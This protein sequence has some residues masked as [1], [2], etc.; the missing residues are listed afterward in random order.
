MNV[1]DFDF[2]TQNFLKEYFTYYFTHYIDYG[3]NTIIFMKKGNFYEIYGLFN[4]EDDNEN[5]IILLSK[6]LDLKIMNDSFQ[7][8]NVT[9]KKMYK[10]I[11][12]GIPEVKLEKYLIKIKDMNFTIVIVD[13]INNNNIITRYVKSII[14][15]GTYISED[16]DINKLTNNTMCLWIEK[17]STKIYFGLSSIDIYTGSSYIYEYNSD[18]AIGEM[19]YTEIERNISQ[20]QPTEFIIISNYTEKEVDIVLE[21]LKLKNTVIHKINIL[22]NK[23]T[24]NCEKQTYQEEILK[25]YYTFNDFS[26]F[27]KNFDTKI[28]A[29]QSYCYL[30]DFINSH[31]NYLLKNLNLPIFE[32]YGTRVYLSNYAYNQLNFIETEYSGKSKYSSIQ[33]MLNNCITPIGKRYFDYKIFN[34]TTDIIYLNKEYNIIEYIISLTIQHKNKIEKL[35]TNICDFEKILRKIFTDK[36]NYK[37][38]YNIYV[39]LITTCSIIDEIN[40]IDNNNIINK[41]LE[42]TINKDKINEIILFIHSN[43]NIENCKMFSKIDDNQYIIPKKDSELYLIYKKN[44]DSTVILE[45]I[46]NYF[47]N[48]INISNKSKIFIDYVKI[49]EDFNFE[50]TIERSKLFTKILDSIIQ[51]II[52]IN[53]TSPIDNQD[54]IYT[55]D[56][57]DITFSKHLKTKYILTCNNIIILQDDI[58]QSKILLNKLNNNQYYT[59]I[60]ELETNYKFFHTLN[61]F[62]SIIDFIYCKASIA[63]KFNYCKPNIELANNS[64]IN[65]IELRH[66]IIE[67]INENEFYTGN[68]LILGEYGIILYGHNYGGK[69]SL[70][71][72][73]GINILLAQSG[74]YVAASKFKYFPYSNIFVLINKNDNM[75][76]NLSLFQ[77][78]MVNINNLLRMANNNSLILMDELVSSTEIVSTEV[79]TMS[80]IET[81]I[82]YKSSFILSSHI[83]TLLK[84]EHIINSINNNLLKI[85]HIEMEFD[86]YFN[87]IIYNRKIKEGSG[88]KIYGVMC[89]KTLNLP[90]DFMNLM[91]SIMNKYFREEKS[92]L[93]LKTSK[94]NSKKLTGIICENCNLEISKDVHH[95]YHQ[96]DADK[97]GFI[98]LESGQI[99]HKNHRLNLRS[100]CK[101]CHILIHSK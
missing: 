95:V 34:P 87:K 100:I 43:F 31:N 82:S 83:H 99:I 51:K 6:T 96:A 85:Y 50:I 97:N 89:T 61:S 32:C 37:Y 84:Y 68:D 7:I 3:I 8:E 62:I 26:V 27:I 73:I 21:Y 23:K 72:S 98:K 55:L 45:N 17:T 4:I 88:S 63:I 22:N 67:I 86:S 74:F 25:K 78:E 79:I 19:M 56:I 69:S 65:T 59:T 2:K 39:V 35:L 49:D 30:L 60:Q 81:L 70:I 12:I 24:E 54:Y 58:I 11:G 16:E 53:Y 29:T 20:K 33:K 64:F 38:I 76:E 10:I 1:C 48:T 44:I 41:Y 36:I 15:S 91:D 5:P 13:E 18:I 46:K 9:T 101:A 94:Y 66:P 57:S 77:N 28:I 80:L 42:F 75:F 90:P 52:T 47:N 71:K 40:E 14:S 92:V 93:E